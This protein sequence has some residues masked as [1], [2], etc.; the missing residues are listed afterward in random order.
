MELLSTASRFIPNYK[1]DL[2]NNVVAVIGGPSSNEF[3]DMS[4]ILN[5][6]KVAQFAYSSAPEMDS[7]TQAVFFHWMFPNAI[8]QYRGILHLLLH[9]GWTWIGVF[10]IDIGNA[11]EV[12]LRTVI[13]MLSKSGICFDFIRNLVGGM[14]SDVDQVE[15]AACETLSFAL[16]RTTNTV[17]FHG[18]FQS[19]LTLRFFLKVSELE[20]MPEYSKVWIMTADV[21]FTS[22]PLQRNW[23]LSFI[24]GSLSLAIT[25]K[26]ISGFHQFLQVRNPALEA[27]DGFLR[28]IW[29][30][31]FSCSFPD[32]SSDVMDGNLCTGKEQLGTLPMTVFEMRMTAHSYSVYTAVYAIARALHALHSSM[33]NQGSVRNRRQKLHQ[34]SW[35]RGKSVLEYALEFWRLAEKLTD[36]LESLRGE[37]FKRGLNPE[38]LE[39]ALERDDPSTV[40]DWIWL[41][42]TAESAWR[43]IQQSPRR[44]DQT[45]DQPRER[46]PEERR[47]SRRQSTGGR[48]ATRAPNLG[49]R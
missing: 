4:T 44:R 2:Q 3:L 47:S 29:Q 28:E 32:L 33:D 7:Q 10:Y 18:E 12:L 17:I 36:W 9:F 46:T 22:L 15:E 31:V 8:H 27:E 5:N 43:Q 37:Y 25:S 16:T 24:H 26:Y 23:D 30:Q 20:D 34:Q 42:G 19:M 40:K 45:R 6:Y 39:R 1:C 14:L 21:D 48:E 41:A 49:F 38:I 35:K 13:P 11:R